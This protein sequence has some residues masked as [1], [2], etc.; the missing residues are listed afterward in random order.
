[1]S[2]AMSHNPVIEKA[3]ATLIERSRLG[4][5]NAIAI[6]AAVG[7]QVRAGKPNPK[8][9]LAYRYMMEFIKRNPPRERRYIDT[10]G[11]DCSFGEL[12]DATRKGRHPKKYGRIL[13]KFFLQQAPDPR[14]CM[15]AAHVL[16][17]GDL[18]DMSKVKRV[19]ANI[20]PDSRGAFSIGYK[21]RGKAS[22][23]AGEM[24]KDAR[25]A[26]FI[27]VLLGTAKLMQDTA[28]NPKARM[29]PMDPVVGW[30]LGE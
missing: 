27:G 8:A 1:M 11:C 17:S 12:R 19:M 22:Q 7:E 18:I 2:L 10:I 15:V 9:K 30:E 13:V 4:D 5:Q 20:P 14:N 6:V 26:F 25:K 3:A 21:H 29:T 16:A 24:P 28:H 23:F